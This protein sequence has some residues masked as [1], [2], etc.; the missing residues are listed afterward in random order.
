[1]ESQANPSA[2]RKL[3]NFWYYHKMKIILPLF[4]VVII[5]VGL[6]AFRSNKPKAD[7]S[8]VLWG[9][10][11]ISD[12]MA[13]KFNKIFEASIKDVNNDGVRNTALLPANFPQKAY[14][15]L[16]GN[17]AQVAILNSRD[18]KI[19][20]AKG[21]FRPLD[22]LFKKYEYNIGSHPEIKM[23]AEQDSTEH[24][25]GL[26]LEGNKLL[27]NLG[28]FKGTYFVISSAGE[29]KENKMIDNGFAM[30]ELLLKNK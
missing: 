18:F 4:A 29:G 14:L 17:E 9:S 2:F 13:E 27:A 25:Y 20:A 26:P 11:G 8:V 21:T 30:L 1:M 5:M 7:V 6:V 10:D 22:D 28:D 23:R 19:Y 24:I 16:A 3:E 15:M 12:V